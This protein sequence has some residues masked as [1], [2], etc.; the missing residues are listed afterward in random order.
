MDICKHQKPKTKLE[1]AIEKIKAT[2]I[3]LPGGMDA[4]DE[5]DTE[6]TSGDYLITVDNLIKSQ[7]SGDI[8][9]ISAETASELVSAL[10]GNLYVVNLNTRTIFKI[11]HA[12][13]EKGDD[14]RWTLPYALA[15][16]AFGP[17]VYEGYS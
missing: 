13:I 2:S 17:K 15:K 10:K 7:M 1:E 11:S 8:T 14:T 9:A 6:D 4:D 12:R 16:K 3:V 5:E